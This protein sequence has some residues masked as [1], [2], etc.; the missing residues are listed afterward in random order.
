MSEVNTFGTEA[1]C[2]KCDRLTAALVETEDT[3]IKQKQKIANLERRI[4]ILE[5][6]N[7]NLYHKNKR[8]E[9]ELGQFD[10][11]VRAAVGLGVDRG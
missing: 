1:T 5:A 8:A 9:R 2:E 11:D 7:R 4:E 10:R 6:R 3:M